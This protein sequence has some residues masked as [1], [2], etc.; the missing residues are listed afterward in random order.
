MNLQEA[1]ALAE[2]ITSAHPRLRYEMRGMGHRRNGYDFLLL[3]PEST[4]GILIYN[5]QMWNDMCAIFLHA[6]PSLVPTFKSIGS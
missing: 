2:Q 5:Q 4:I 6:L 3:L 1:T